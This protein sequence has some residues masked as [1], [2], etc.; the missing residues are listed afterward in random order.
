MTLINQPEDNKIAMLANLQ[1]NYK[2]QSSKFFCH[3]KAED[4]GCEFR[5]H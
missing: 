4:N 1:C 3:S 2:Y 5:K